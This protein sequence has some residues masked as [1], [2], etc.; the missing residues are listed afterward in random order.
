[1]SQTLPTPIPFSFPAE[2]PHAGIPLGNGNFGVLIW[3]GGT[4]LRLTINRQDYWQH[5]GEITWSEDIGYERM[6]AYVSQRPLAFDDPAIMGLKTPG[7]PRPTRLPVGRFD[8]VLGG[9]ILSAVLHLATGTASVTTTAGKVELVMMREQP[10]L[11]IRGPILAITPVPNDSPEVTRYRQQ[12]QMPEPSLFRGNQMRGWVQEGLDGQVLGAGAGMWGAGLGGTSAA[13]RISSRIAWIGCVLSHSATDA[14]ETLQDLLGALE[15][16]HPAF[17]D[18]QAHSAAFYQGWWQQSAWVKIAHRPTQILFDL[19]MYK[20]SGLTRP[21]GP[22]PTLQGPWVEDDRM[23]P[24][25]SDYH[26]N[27]NYQMCHWPMLAGN[28]PELF[29]PGIRMLKKWFPQMREYARK[30]TGAEDALML[31]HAVDDRCIPADTNW[32]CQFDPGSIGWTALIYWDLYRY[33]GDRSLLADFSYPMLRGALRLYESML[34]ETASGFILP[35]APTP[36]FFPTHEGLPDLPDWGE[37][38]SFQLAILHALLRAVLQSMEILGLEE[39]AQ[40]R[41]RDIQARLPRACVEDG[42]IQLFKGLDL[43]R[44]HRHPSHLA[45]IYPFDTLDLAGADHDVVKNSLARWVE[46]GTGAWSG[47]CVP[48]AAILWARAGEAGAAGAM[49]EQYRRFFTGPNY[50]SRHDA[51]QDG[52]TIFRGSPHI[53]QIDAAMGVVTAILEMLAHEKNGEIC[54][55][56]A[57]PEEWGDV[58]FGNLFLPGGR[59][60]HGVRTDGKWVDLGIVEPT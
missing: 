8:L 45:G 46:M 20:L 7:T 26:F 30:F 18:A 41:W 34:Q 10:V 4:T 15:G 14:R 29:E 51:V 42:R 40:A 32:R 44:S 35:M 38:P 52:F 9:S 43:V 53:M 22:A 24:W 5:A 28:H 19:G 23:P 33:T 12:Y 25:G 6:C 37:N 13:D 59:F 48:W 47:W 36:E 56:P 58:A 54:L 57:V 3:G 11:V 16:Q 17:E 39:P 21:G 49:V 27:I 1:M 50:A 2:T 60:A 31:P 55:A